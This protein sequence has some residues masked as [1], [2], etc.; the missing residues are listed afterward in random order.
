MTPMRTQHSLA[1]QTFTVPLIQ[2]E[3][4]REEA[5]QQVADALQY[6]QKVSGD[7]FSRISQ[8]V[9]LSRSQ[10]Q[11]IG[12]RVSLA[13]AKIEKIKGSKKAI[14]VFS[15]AKYPAP[16]RLQEYSSI[17]MGA[18]DSGLQ[19]R[20]RH[21]IQ[22]KH[23][24]LDER[25]LQEKLKYFPVCVSTKPEPEDEA[26]EGLGGLPSNINSVSSLLLF[27]TTEN[28]YKKYVFLDPL[29]GAVTKTH[30]MLGTETE[31]KLF[32]APLSI[33]KREQLE[34]QVPENYFYV[35][36]LG[37]VPEIDVPSYL[38]DLPGIADDLMYSADLGPGIAP[39]APGTIPELPTF[40]TEVAEPFKPNLED[41]VLT[42]PPPPPPPAPAVLVSAPP[43]PPPLQT[44]ASPGQGS[45]DEHS[46]SPS[47]PVQG[48]PKEV[49]DPSSGRATLLE[50]IRQAGGI[51][52]AKL[53]S[54]KERKL[55]KKKQ[56]EQEQVRATGQGG[57]LMSDL[58]NKLV[59][60][61]KGISGKGPGSGASEGPGGA[62]ARMSDS[63]PPLPPPQQ[64]PGEDEDEWES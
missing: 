24:P 13:Q 54:V 52:K 44:V 40:H 16:E 27:N 60:R 56:K 30:V 38:P 43:P 5:I 3:L 2:P 8:R 35:P 15:S 45:E 18:Q 51:G 4:R 6:L 14:K 46:T 55:E 21:R 48:A 50:S 39:S 62:F 34:Q 12:E 61:R 7:I 53:R 19:R 64:P 63:I 37:Q 31:E 1:G 9:E 23:R 28:L 33:S 41:G 32:D 20:P 26:E 42:P 22:S 49:V 10:L 47:A 59:M 17:F 29:A 57:D 58:F 11:A 36:D 25:A